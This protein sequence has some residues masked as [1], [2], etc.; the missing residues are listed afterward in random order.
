MRRFSLTLDKIDGLYLVYSNFFANK[1]IFKVRKTILNIVL[2][3]QKFDWN[4][5]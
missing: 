1:I 2:F 3:A 4:W 5:A